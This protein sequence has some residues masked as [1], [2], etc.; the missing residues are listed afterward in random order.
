MRLKARGTW[1]TLCIQRACLELAQRFQGTC[2][3][4]DSEIGRPVRGVATA[5]STQSREAAT[6]SASAS[7]ALALWPPFPLT[8]PS[9]VPMH[10]LHT[11]SDAACVRTLC[12]C[13]QHHR[14]QH[15][16]HLHPAICGPHAD[17][18]RVR[19]SGVACKGAL[20]PAGTPHLH[21]SCGCVGMGMLVAGCAG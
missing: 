16:T 9:P 5:G 3:Q 20:Q 18:L 6:P 15:H 7:G 12:M 14:L 2:K 1:H 4:D 19:V 10:T 11:R 17:A 21:R 13:A 8:P